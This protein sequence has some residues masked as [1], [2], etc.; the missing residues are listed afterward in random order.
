MHMIL[1]CKAGEAPPNKSTLS[2]PHQPSCELPPCVCACVHLCVCV[3]VCACVCMFVRVCMCVCVWKRTVG[4]GRSIACSARAHLSHMRAC[5]L[6]ALC[7][8]MLC[9]PCVL[10]CC[11]PCLQGRSTRTSPQLG[12]GRTP[13]AS[14]P[15]Q[16]GG[17]AGLHLP[18]A[19]PGPG[20]PS[21]RRPTSALSPGVRLEAVRV[22]VRVDVGSGSGL[23]L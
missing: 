13:S 9:A 14:M 20:A 4:W 11:A 23:K 2:H 16:A 19:T 10:E 18:G 22:G 6:H 12:W 15:H 7:A 3:H 1:H 8:C 17:Q 21:V 5:M